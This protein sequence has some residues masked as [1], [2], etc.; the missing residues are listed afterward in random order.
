MNRVLNAFGIHGYGVSLREVRRYYRFLIPYFRPYWKG[1]AGL[2][3]IMVANIGMTLFVAGFLKNITEAA[4]QHHLQTVW[5]LLALGATLFGAAGVMGFCNTYL[6]TSITNQVKRDVTAD[7]FD[8][9]LHLPVSSMTSFHSGDAVSRLT[10]D[11]GTATGGVGTN[12]INILYLPIMAASSFLYLFHLNRQLSIL[13]IS[14]GPVA[15]IAVVLFSKYMRTNGKAMQKQLGIIYSLINES[16]VGH[17]VIRSFVLEHIFSKKYRKANNAFVSLELKGAI[18]RGGFFLCTQ[19]VGAAAFLLS[20]GL[21]AADVARGT[22]SVGSLLAFTS[23]LQHLVSPFTGMAHQVGGLQ[24]SLAAAERIWEV[25]DVPTERE[26]GEARMRRAGHSLCF[27][28]VSLDYDG[29]RNAISNVSCSIPAGAVVALV[30]PSGAGKSTLFHLLLRFYEPT[31]GRILLDETPIDQFSVRDLRYLISFVPQETH[32]FSG[33]IR[34]NLRYGRPSASDSDILRAAKDANIH[35]FIVSLPKGYDTEIGERGLRL[36]GGQRQRISI[37]RAILKDAPILLLDE[38]TSALDSETEQL[39]QDALDK[40]M[41]HRTTIVIAH[42]LST[43]RNADAIFVMDDGHLVE[44]GTH[45][46]L[47]HQNGLYSHLYR[48][49]FREEQVGVVERDPNAEII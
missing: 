14:F 36:S 43:V 17:M 15:L 46:D 2:I 8:K 34:E 31:S 11:V 37:A 28:N 32:L 7:L 49:Q 6:S 23:L 20:L 39:I 25:F 47:I 44:K 4:L 24:R 5:R 35:E 33:T 21:G 22:M 13:C 45:H 16:L 26:G 41:R 48:L 3:A 18:L 30:G 42:R 38:A 10:N 27:R 12:L 9:L 1:Y 19:F 29:S 40:L